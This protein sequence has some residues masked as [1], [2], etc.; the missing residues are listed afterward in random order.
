MAWYTLPTEKG[1]FMD[2]KLLILSLSLLS[3]GAW[4]QKLVVGTPELHRIAEYQQALVKH[5]AVAKDPV[6]VSYGDAMERLFFILAGQV[7]A[8]DQTFQRALS[9]KF[10]VNA[11]DSRRIGEVAS[12]AFSFAGTVRNNAS[13]RYDEICTE[14]VNAAPGTVSAI[15]LAAKLEQ[16]EADQSAQLTALYR[17]ALAD[18]SPS[19]RLALEAY[20]DKEFRAQI[21]WR[22][23]LVG[24]A[25]DVP[26]G[27]L[28]QRTGSCRER[29]AQ[30]PSDKAFKVSAGDVVVP[31]PKTDQP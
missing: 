19:G 3:T 20:V 2:R 21:A 4:A 7:G 25:T 8:G 13:A 14:L 17:A 12:H 26:D 24:L 11:E 5:A 1:D 15:D 18:V 30:S 31:T 22:H 10:A 27:F 16:V 29:L 9:A 23:D 28:E 6:E